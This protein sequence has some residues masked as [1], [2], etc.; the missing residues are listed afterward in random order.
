MT[1]NTLLVIKVTIAFDTFGDVGQ[2]IV[3]RIFHP[4]L[5][6]I[7]LVIVILVKKKSTFQDI[8]D[9]E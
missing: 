8:W 9:S 3:L 4:C 5:M 7:Q 6:V 1:D 2:V